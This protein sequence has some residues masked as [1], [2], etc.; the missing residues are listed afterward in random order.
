MKNQNK[1]LLTG[2]GLILASTLY[3][4]QAQPSTSTTKSTIGSL[5][6]TFVKNP[7]YT[8]SEHILSVQNQ[9]AYKI[10]SIIFDNCTA[11]IS[12][13]GSGQELEF[14]INHK[15]SDYDIAKNTVTEEQYLRMFNKE[16]KLL[17]INLNIT[18]DEV[19]M[20]TLTNMF[21]IYLFDCQNNN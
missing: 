2:L 19:K 12:L 18:K 17:S 9:G 5:F 21:Q 3:S 20:S 4:P 10:E 8:K 13:A 15:S 11:T 7:E 6:K 1:K 16:N 14:D